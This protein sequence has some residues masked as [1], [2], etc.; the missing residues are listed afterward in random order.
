MLSK[1]RCA[2]QPGT[3]PFTQRTDKQSDE[4]QVWPEAVKVFAGL[5]RDIRPSP[6][7]GC[8]ASGEGALPRL[9]VLLRAR[10]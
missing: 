7:Q 5:G 9:G 6:G 8:A 1:E 4:N 2:L 3:N 10:L